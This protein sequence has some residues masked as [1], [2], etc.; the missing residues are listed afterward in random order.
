M[1]FPEL[2]WRGCR[3]SQPQ[4]NIGK[5]LLQ[6]L[7]PLLFPEKS[8]YQ[9]KPPPLSVLLPRNPSQAGEESAQL[10]GKGEASHD[11]EEK[12]KGHVGLSLVPSPLPPRLPWLGLEGKVGLETHGR[13]HRWLQEPESLRSQQVCRGGRVVLGR[14]EGAGHIRLFL[15]IVHYLICP[16]ILSPTSCGVSHQSLGCSG[17]QGSPGP[18]ST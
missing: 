4:P 16:F 8:K 1:H 14:Q 11:A 7:S 9:A 10:L 12:N 5:P 3:S 15:Y 18:S 13:G 17:E 2:S 6:Q